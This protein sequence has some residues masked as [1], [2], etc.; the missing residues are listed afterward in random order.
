MTV[1]EIK[2]EL[3]RMLPLVT[4]KG[5]I[6]PLV[7]YLISTA[8]E[9]VVQVVWF[10]P[11][12]GMKRAKSLAE[13]AAWIDALPTQGGNMSAPTYEQLAALVV[14]LRDHKATVISGR[15]RNPEDDVDD[16]MPWAEFEAFQ[17]DAARLIPKLPKAKVK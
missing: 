5:I 16:L 4:A 1:E 2:A 6:A 13:C 10:Q 9:P 3:D 15:R 8:G 7:E 17:D 14:E 11:V 12:F